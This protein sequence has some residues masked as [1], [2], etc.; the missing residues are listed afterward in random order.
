MRLN[1]KDDKKYAI[2]QLY[3]EISADTAAVSW[4]NR[5]VIGLLLKSS[6]TSVNTFCSDCCSLSTP[7]VLTERFGPASKL[8]TQDCY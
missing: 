6:S 3:G 1:S 8:L 7:V 5:A 2:T 4:P